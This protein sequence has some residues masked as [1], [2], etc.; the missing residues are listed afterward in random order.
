MTEI[1]QFCFKSCTI[2]LSTII[3]NIR[4]AAVTERLRVTIRVVEN[5]AKSLKV[6]QGQSKLHRLVGRV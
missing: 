4:S 1:F 6:I 2:V 3:I 5:F